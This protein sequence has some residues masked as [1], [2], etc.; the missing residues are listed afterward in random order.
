MRS[1]SGEGRCMRRRGFAAGPRHSENSR[2][3]G[4]HAVFK[5]CF[6]FEDSYFIGDLKK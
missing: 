3:A 1:G 6:E 2:H 5:A 4:P